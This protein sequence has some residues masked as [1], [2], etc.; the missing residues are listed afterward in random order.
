VTYV[1]C[2]GTIMHNTRILVDFVVVNSKYSNKDAILVPD[3]ALCQEDVT[4]E[5]C[6]STHLLPWH[7]MEVCDQ[8]Q[9]PTS[10]TTRK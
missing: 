1:S 10:L 2:A 7:S 9:S 5:R 3:Y 8:L 6:C 4:V